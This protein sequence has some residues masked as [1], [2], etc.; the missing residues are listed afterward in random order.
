MLVGAVW[1]GQKNSLCPQELTRWTKPGSSELSPS[2]CQKPLPPAPTQPATFSSPSLWV[3]LAYGGYWEAYWVY[4][5]FCGGEQGGKSPAAQWLQR[6]LVGHE[7]TYAAPWGGDTGPAGLKGGGHICRVTATDILLHPYVQPAVLY[8][9]VYGVW[10]SQPSLAGD[11][12]IAP[13][14]LGVHTPCSTSSCATSRSSPRARLPAEPWVP[15]SP[16]EDV[17]LD[18]LQISAISTWRNQVTEH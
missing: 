7:C 13:G 14:A 4:F 10:L 2:A 12:C 3:P 5:S 18:A 16:W 9:V 17:G 15:T 6:P 11:T 8:A 1:M